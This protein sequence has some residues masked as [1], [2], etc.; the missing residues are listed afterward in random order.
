M[1]DYR[2][3]W[4]DLAEGLRKFGGPEESLK[5]ILMGV[6]RLP[7]DEALEHAL[8]DTVAD[9]LLN[10]VDT[11]LGAREPWARSMALV[12]EGQP[13]FDVPRFMRHATSDS[14]DDSGA[15]NEEN[16]EEAMKVS[17]QVG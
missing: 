12:L 3:A 4:I 10:V 2:R 11:G 16:P 13:D 5:E 1:T 14:A 17:I 6:F 8:L 9:A 7:V 15:Y